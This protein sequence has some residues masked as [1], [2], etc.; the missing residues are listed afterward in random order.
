MKLRSLVTRFRFPFSE[1]TTAKVV[2]GY[3]LFAGVNGP[4]GRPFS[5]VLCKCNPSVSQCHGGVKPLWA[6][7][8][9]FVT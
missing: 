9:R 1:A 6:F 2:I 3:H 5:E 4:I 8:R 7:V